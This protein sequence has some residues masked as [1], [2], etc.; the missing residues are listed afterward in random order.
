MSNVA[1]IAPIVAMLNL[2]LGG[3]SFIYA[4]T[5]GCPALPIQDAEGRHR[6]DGCMICQ[7]TECRTLSE[8]TTMASAPGTSSRTLTLVFGSPQ[9]LRRPVPLSQDASAHRS[10]APFGTNA[11]LI[12]HQRLLLCKFAVLE[13]PSIAASDQDEVGANLPRAREIEALLVREPIQL[14]CTCN[15]IC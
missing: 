3:L 10:S 1:T 12:S 2:E 14:D 8:S 9:K 6:F 5:T 13:G 7:Q 15:M 4:S 11:Q